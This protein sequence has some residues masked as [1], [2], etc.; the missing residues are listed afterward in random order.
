M[1]VIKDPDIQDTVT[2]IALFHQSIQAGEGS[3]AE[4][5]QGQ[6][7]KVERESLHPIAVAN[8]MIIIL[9]LPTDM[10]AEIYLM[11]LDQEACL[12]V[13]VMTAITAKEEVR[14]NLAVVAIQEASPDTQMMIALTLTESPNLVAKA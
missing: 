6:E 13:L 7:A 1:L 8:P 10:T 12:P 11:P 5:D 3:V 9:P 14:E 4:T 2:E